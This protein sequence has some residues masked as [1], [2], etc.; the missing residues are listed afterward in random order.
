MGT[1]GSKAK[2]S[3][4]EAKK[5][6]EANEAKK[7]AKEEKKKEKKKEKEARKA[8]KEERKLTAEELDARLTERVFENTPDPR[9]PL[10]DQFEF[11]KAVSEN[12]PPPRSTPR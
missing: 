9:L 6:R 10:A 5:E 12:R 3:E 4:E 2:L 7:A 1:S 8:Y 11:M